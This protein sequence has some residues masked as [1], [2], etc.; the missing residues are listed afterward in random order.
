MLEGT[1]RDFLSLRLHL[2]RRAGALCFGQA[3]MIS[4][5]LSSALLSIRRSGYWITTTISGD[6]LSMS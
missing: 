4:G 1:R 6:E 5:P 3:P 2:L